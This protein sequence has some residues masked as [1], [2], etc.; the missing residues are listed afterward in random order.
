M[1]ALWVT[2]LAHRKP[3]SAA[4]PRQTFGIRGQDKRNARQKYIHYKIFHSSYI[5]REFM[6]IGG[7][8]LGWS[9]WR[10]YSKVHVLQFD[11]KVH[12]LQFDSKVHV[13]QFDSKV[14]VLQFDSKVH[15]LQFDSKVHVLQFDN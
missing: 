15:V 8:Q 2:T 9:D 14:H 10:Y 1:A 5:L 13:L 3:A 6:I 12:V 4:L 7:L 11:S